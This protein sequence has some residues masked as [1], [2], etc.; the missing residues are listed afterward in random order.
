LHI[1]A[2]DLRRDDTHFTKVRRAHR[3]GRAFGIRALAVRTDLQI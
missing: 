2:I 3:G 1:L